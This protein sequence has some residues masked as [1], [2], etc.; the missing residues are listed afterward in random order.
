ALATPIAFD[1]GKRTSVK[2]MEE[3]EPTAVKE[4]EA[5]P[6]FTLAT[7]SGDSVTL[8]K[9]HG[10]V[11]VL[12]FWATWCGPCKM[13]LPK[14]QEFAKWAESS[15]QPIKVYAVDVWE[16]TTGA[17]QTKEKVGEFWKSKGYT[18]PTL[19]DLDQ[20]VVKKYG[21]QSIP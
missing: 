4:G 15:G 2:T 12:D 1:A 21:F 8:S 7:L 3:L 11:V 5:A 6:D 17:D 16:H 13:A 14:I 18:F 19:L 9:L 20:A 10:S